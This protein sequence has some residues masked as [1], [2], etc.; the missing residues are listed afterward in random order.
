M[1]AFPK[2]ASVLLDVAVDKTLDY[3][4]DETLLSQIKRGSRVEVPLKRSLQ[5]GFVLELKSSPSFPRVKAIKRMLNE[6]ELL[7]EELFELATWMAK[8]YCAPLR[9]VLK[10]IIPSSV[11]SDLNHKQQLF[12]MRGK[13]RED[14]RKTCEKLRVRNPAQAAV[15]DVLLKVKKGILLTELLE[16]AQV[17]KSPVNTLANQGL[18]TLDIVRIDRSPLINE[19]YFRTKPKVLNDEQSLSLK[20][21]IQSLDKQTF[22]THLL[23]GVTGSGKT[24]VY[25][26]AIDH[27]LS[28]GRGSIM[29]V[30]EISLTPQ[31]VERFR[32]RFE[33]NIAILH[34]RLSKGERF[35]E[36]H[37]IRRGKASIIIGARSA[38]FSPLPNLGLVIVDEEHE[39][40]YKQTEEA[41]CYNARDVAV[42]RGFLKGCTVLLGSATPSLESFQNAQNG[43]YTLSKLLKRADSAK[44]P[45]VTIVDMNAEQEKNKSLHTFSPLLLKKIEEA[46]SRGEQSILFLNR[47]G[48]HSMQICLTCQTPV[49]CP[50]CDLS[51]TF[52]YKNNTLSCHLCSYEISPP[53][54]HCRECKSCN[55]MKY[56]GVGTE[57]VERSLHA[58][59]PQ[60]RSL[61]MDADTTRHK[62]SHERLLR[63]FRTGKAD[64]LIGTQMIAKGLHF[65]QVTLV[66]ILNSDASLHIP[67]FR[68]SERVFQLLTQVAG[69]AGRGDREGEVIIQSRM[70]DNSTIE[71]ASKQDYIGFYEQ[72]IETRKMFHFPPFTRMVKYT[73]SGTD[74][75][76]T[77]A[78]A[79]AFY[80]ELIKGLLPSYQASP[81]SPAGYAKVKERFRFQFLI[82]GPH[83]LPINTQALQSK[84]KIP[85]PKGIR[86]HIDIDPLSTF[87]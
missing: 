62:G 54:L 14:L 16:K 55:N 65:P 1:T 6:H 77:L 53:P 37:K 79:E 48:Y 75:K 43:K 51:L 84:E 15:L 39:G 60:I 11:R 33:D 73:F 44:L 80:Q 35:D 27:T 86:M 52:H 74:E 20:K 8:Y 18:I 47:R 22:E 72:E 68:S 12:V 28:L 67:D 24:E 42:M 2:Y 50:F 34:H 63:D 21:I 66:G 41:P 85:P 64:V 78:Y 83:I 58:I 10:A 49:K 70:P 3:G 81:V 56:R 32:S 40:S 76:K 29:L 7:N 61:R 9:Q 59:F 25:L 31:T 13:T 19:E 5:K 17:S 82:R 23:Y 87:F 4:V 45:Q 57:Q 36:W 46:T 30:P 69:R 38:I 71:L 26:Q